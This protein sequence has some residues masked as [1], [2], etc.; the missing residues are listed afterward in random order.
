MRCV[1]LGLLGLG[2]CGRV[3]FDPIG[4]APGSDGMP[5]NDSSTTPIDAPP[6]ACEQAITVG[7]GRTVPTSTCTFPD[8]LDSCGPAGRQEVV[9]RFVAPMS[10]SYTYAAY[11]PGTTTGSNSTQ[12]VDGPC[13]PVSG[14]CAGTTRRMFS[15]GQIVYFVVEASAA[16][17]AMIEFEITSP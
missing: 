4:G 14:G 1:L 7:I 3:G 16:A 8:R 9:F 5:G 2:A 11:N 10:A 17:C 6:T 15:A 13:V 12:T